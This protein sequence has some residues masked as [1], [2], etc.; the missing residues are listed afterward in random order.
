[1]WPAG[2]NSTE[3]RISFQNQMRIPHDAQMLYLGA[4]LGSAQAAVSLFFR[5]G[6][7]FRPATP[8]GHVGTAPAPSDSGSNSLC[9]SWSWGSRAE[10]QLVPC[11]SAAFARLAQDLEHFWVFN[12]GYMYHPF[13]STLVEGLSADKGMGSWRI[14]NRSI[15]DLNRIG[16]DIQSLAKGN[17]FICIGVDQR[18]MMIRIS[19]TMI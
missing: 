3:C 15:V 2:G 14:D 16:A 9:V 13:M 12:T 11:R 7:S 18:N 19:M 17:I 8:A 1:M 10:L 5:R 4:V 6:A